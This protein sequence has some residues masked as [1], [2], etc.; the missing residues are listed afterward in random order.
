LEQVNL[1]GTRVRNVDPLSESPIKMLWLSHCPVEDISPLKKTPL[2]SLTLED[3]GVTDISCFA[4][5]SIERLHVGGCAVEDL[6]PLKSM[7]LTRLIFAPGR[8]KKGMDVARAMPTINEIGTSFDERL[9]PAEFWQL[10]DAGKI[11]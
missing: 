8:V 7:R 11:K 3:T 9:R 1:V 6:T 4:G 5:H 10:Y 2:V